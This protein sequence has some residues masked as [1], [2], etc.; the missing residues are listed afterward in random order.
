MTVALGVLSSLP[1]AEH[2]VFKGGS[3]LRT[4]YF[5]EHRFSEDLDFTVRADVAADILAEEDRFLEAG[6]R[7]GVRVTRVHAV[8]SRRSSSSLAV[9]YDDMN[10][11]GNRIRLELS[12][13]ET[14]V[15]PA[16]PRPIRDPYGVLDG[17]PRVPT[18]DLREI[19][20]EKIRALYMR[21]E[22]RDLFDLWVLARRGV[23]LEVPLV[24][25]KLAW[26]GHGVTYA[27]PA[28][29]E[30]IKRLGATWDR[31]LAP[32]LAEV[33]PFS[34]VAERTIRAFSSD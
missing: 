7:A 25:A 12:L 6:R 31:D 9:R 34:E 15:L 24:D 14:V 22:P 18:M 10:G 19:L 21:S 11:H 1:C 2:L 32:L 16:E 26:W 17:R 13:R 3:A 27:P 23:P 33:P 5:E 28:V 8:R 4:V 30:R 29:R 20:A